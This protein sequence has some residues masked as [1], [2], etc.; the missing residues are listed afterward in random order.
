MDYRTLLS[1][2]Y[3]TLLQHLIISG[4]VRVFHLLRTSDRNGLKMPCCA[5]YAQCSR[6]R[7]VGMKLPGLAKTTAYTGIKSLSS[8]TR[9]IM[10]HFDFSC[11]S[12][13]TFFTS[14]TVV[15][16][17]MICLAFIERVPRTLSVTGSIP[18]VIYVCTN[19]GQLFHYPNT[20]Y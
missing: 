6:I 10:L 3:C 12:L 7:P 9:V 11:Y 5:E 8:E 18:C 13:L 15:W 2:V 20:S 17:V 1:T 19:W 4:K 16:T 14:V